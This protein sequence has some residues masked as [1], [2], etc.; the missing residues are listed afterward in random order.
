MLATNDGNNAVKAAALS[1]LGDWKIKEQKELLL[2]SIKDS[3]YLVA[4]NALAALQ[5]IDDNLAYTLAKEH[6][7]EKPNTE[8]DENAWMVLALK[9]KEEDTLAFK[10]LA[11]NKHDAEKR[12]HIAGNLLLFALST[13][14]ESAFTMCLHLL[15]DKI[16]ETE[17]KNYRTYYAGFLFKI[18]ENIKLRLSKSSKSPLLLREM[19]LL[20]A[21]AKALLAS[22]KEEEVQA[23][24]QKVI[25]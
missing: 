5:Q 6:I 2:Q 4:G 17:N 14:S 23:V 15:A 11:L 7:N 12:N 19:E 16:Q 25:Q 9:A 22:E 20:K 24:Y 21:K 8:L 10:N 13:K 1:I 18:K 3:S